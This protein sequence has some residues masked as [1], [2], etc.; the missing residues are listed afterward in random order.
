MQINILPL[1]GHD[2]MVARMILDIYV[3]ELDGIMKIA[4]NVFLAFE[5]NCKIEKSFFLK[6][7]SR[8]LK[9]S[10]LD[11]QNQDGKVVLRVPGWIWARDDGFSLPSSQILVK[12]MK[13]L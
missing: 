10:F 6:S 5:E 4:K 2:G 3:V 1:F 13:I 9:N 7:I 12:I 11:P 8:K